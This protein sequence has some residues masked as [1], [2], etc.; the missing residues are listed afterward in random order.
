MFEPTRDHVQRGAV[1]PVQCPLW[2]LSQV[3]VRKTEG[4]VSPDEHAQGWGENLTDSYEDIL[5]RSYVKAMGRVASAKE[6]KVRMSEAVI[7][8]IEQFARETNSAPTI[9]ARPGFIVARSEGMPSGLLSRRIPY[10]KSGGPPNCQQSKAPGR[11]DVMFRLLRFT[12]GISLRANFKV[13]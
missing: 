7:F 9:E 3:V 11:K 5:S 1:E 6:N 2:E 13:R 12:E 10:G 8:R 4:N